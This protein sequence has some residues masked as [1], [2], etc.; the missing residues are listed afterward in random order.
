MTGAVY[1][2]ADPYGLG[3]ERKETTLLFYTNVPK[4]REQYRAYAGFA[5]CLLPYD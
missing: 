1:F 5:H 4:T 2:H 3:R